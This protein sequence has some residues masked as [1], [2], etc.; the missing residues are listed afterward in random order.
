MY[1]IGGESESVNILSDPLQNIPQYKQNGLWRAIVV[2]N[3]DPE[4]RGRLQVRILHLHLDESFGLKLLTLSN[5]ATAQDGSASSSGEG[6]LVQVSATTLPAPTPMVAMA[7]VKNE[8]C[9]WADPAFP[10]GGNRDQGSFALPE[11]GSTVWVGFEM[12]YTA[13]PVWLGAWYGSTELPPE[14]NPVDPSK[15]RLMKT[16]DGKLMLF[17]DNPANSRILIIDHPAAAD[18]DVGYIEISQTAGTTVVHRGKYSTLTYSRITMEDD[19]INV[20]VKGTAANTS[21]VLLTPVTLQAQQTTGAGVSTVAMVGGDTTITTTGNVTLNVTGNVMINAVDATL[22]TSGDVVLDSTGDATINAVD[23]HINASGNVSLGSG[24]ALGVMLDAMI[25]KFN[26]H[27]HNHPAGT[28]PPIY[29]DPPDAPHLL[30]AGTDSSLT[31]TA[32]V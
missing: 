21:K 25:A 3:V 10:W 19:N 23:A 32:K 17:D 18:E 1:K 28:F 4:I 7:G 26:G 22:T 2:N 30:V 24:G 12:G 11:I 6:G 13:Y 29:S 9:P 15:V 8:H 27:I 16:P 20:E 5:N 14:I 31:V